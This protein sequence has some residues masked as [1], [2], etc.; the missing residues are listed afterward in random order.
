MSWLTQAAK[1]APDLRVLLALLLLGLLGWMF[2]ALSD[3]VQEGDTHH[4]DEWVLLA[5]RDPAD[6][7]KI[8]GP[9]LLANAAIDITALGSP[10]ILTLLVAIVT[11]VLLLT[12]RL[13]TAITVVAATVGGGAV[14]LGL[15][16]L[17]DRPRPEIVPHLTEVATASYPS[18]HA[19]LSAVV[20]L[21]LGTLGARFTSQRRLRVYF[22]AIAFLL[23]LLVGA[24]RVY[25]GVHYP[26]D[27]LAGWCAGVAWALTV[28][29]VVW[30]LQHRG[31]LDRGAY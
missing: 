14:T 26:S 3:E 25:L 12:H 20:Y 1:R 9:P 5:L 2:V 7:E 6:P 24:S 22:I 18:G 17:F 21:T 31:K 23:T 8:V 15:K 4:I 11:G 30:F 28:G 13:R 10:T 19:L 16:V 27:V 29:L